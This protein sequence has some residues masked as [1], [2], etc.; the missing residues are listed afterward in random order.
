MIKKNILDKFFNPKSVALIGAKDDVGSV[1]FGLVKNLMQ[2]TEGRDVYY[3]NPFRSEVSGEKTYSKIIDIVGK[4]DLA[5]IVV[6]VDSVLQ[7]IGD[8]IQKKVGGV[9]IIT[10]GFGETGEKGRR[11][12]D[13]VTELL[14]KAMIPLIGPNCLGVLNT[15]NNLNASFS[16]LSPKKGSIAFLSQSGALLNTFMDMANSK[17]MGFSKLVSYGNEADIDLADLIEYL[18]EDESTEVICF[19]VEAIKDGQRFM[20]VASRISKIKPLIVI[21]SGRTKLGQEAVATHT[22]SI[23][24]DYQIYEAAFR[25]SG[26]I[27]ADTIEEM[28]DFAKVLVMC[29]RCSSGVGIITNGGGAGVLATDYCEVEGVLLSEISS[30]KIKKSDK[31]DVLRALP[32]I[33]NPLDLIGDAL[34]DRYLTGVELFLSQQQIKAV[35]V[36]ETTQIMT[37]PMENAKN[38][39][40]LKKKYPNKPIVCCFLGGDLVLEASKFLE[41]NSV[42]NFF[43][44]KRAVRAIKNLIND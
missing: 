29:P 18:G 37:I 32:T 9:M 8:C 34:P 11:I 24:G 42:P 43:E 5:I 36:I 26:V 20:K 39:V 13:N 25:Q 17:G 23:A 14:N 44:L 28:L 33:R 6:P 22:G 27:L 38:I 4:I 31:K 1:G 15:Q 41:S 35:L 21:K 7:V 10:A 40:K 3:V 12:E 2:G 30:A 19:Y 16:S